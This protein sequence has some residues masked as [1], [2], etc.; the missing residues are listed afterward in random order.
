M[1]IW[2][3]DSTRVLVPTDYKYMTD[4]SR[5]LLRLEQGWFVSIRKA[6]RSAALPVDCVDCTS[7]GVMSAAMAIKSRQRCRV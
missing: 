1:V 4:P 5:V 7:V 2:L 6:R 3:K